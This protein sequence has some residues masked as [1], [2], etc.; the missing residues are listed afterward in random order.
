MNVHAESNQPTQRP[1]GP[2]VLMVGLGATGVS[3]ARYLLGLGQAVRVL[4][5]RVDPPGLA[6]LGALREALDLRLGS[7]DVAALDG[8]TEVVVSPGVSL[9]EPLLVEAQRRGLRLIGDIEIFARVAPARIAAI[10]GSNGKSTVT[11]LVAELAAAGGLKVRAGANLGTPALD[12]LEGDVPDF[13][14]LELSSFQLET[15]HSLRPRAACVLNITADHID[16][17][18]SMERYIAAKVRILSDAG[19]VVL[20]R[21]DR[22]VMAMWDNRTP[23]I[24]FGLDAPGAG[25]YGLIETPQGLVLARGETELMPASR[26]KLRGRHNLANALAALAITEALGLEP[27]GLL[28]ALAAF[29]GLPHRAEWVAE[30]GGVTWINDSKGTNV[31]AA[32]AAIGG[33]SG[34]V[35]LIAGGDGKGADFAPLA[36]AARGRVRAAVLLGRDA[37]LLAAALEGACPTVQV[38]GIEEAVDAAARLALPGDTV[39]LSPAC[40]STD[41]YRDYTERGRRFAAAARAAGA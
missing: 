12:L 28:D 29:P 20:N 13:Y 7:F 9:G 27:A 30:H 38:G 37:A 17:H 1:G 34:P 41:M 8:V 25:E 31:G 16:R 21:D 4:D 19:I 5:S 10:T 24:R 33:M 3:C 23:C 2:P 36:A 11:S 18:G 35:V 6:R 22:L 39:L 32:V 14:L 26:L 40:A 15:T